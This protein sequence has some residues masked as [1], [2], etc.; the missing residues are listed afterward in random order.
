MACTEAEL[1]GAA[2]ART[3]A[4]KTIYANSDDSALGRHANRYGLIRAVIEF[5]LLQMFQKKRTPSPARSK[6]A[7]SGINHSEARGKNVSGIMVSMHGQTNLFQIVLA[8]SAS[9]RLA[10]GLHGRQQQRDQEA[11]NRNHHQYFDQREATREEGPGK[12]LA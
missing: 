10:P 2:L 12:L 11:D 7:A 8:L 9:C 6:I 3:G 5:R 4:E 1:D